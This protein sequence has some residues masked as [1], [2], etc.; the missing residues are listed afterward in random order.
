MDSSLILVFTAF[1]ACAGWLVAVVAVVVAR[2]P[3]RPPVG[4]KTLDLGPEP[5]AVVNFLVH[6]FTVT[7]DAVPA[8]LIDLAARNVVDIEERGPDVFYVRLRATA[9]EPLTPYERRV[10]EHLRRHVRDGVVPAAALTTGPEAES[11]RW[12]RGFDAEVVADAKARGLSQDAVDGGVFTVLSMASAIPALVIGLVTDLRWGGVAF[13]GAISLLG[14]LRKRHPQRETDAGM[15]AGSRWLGVRAELADNPEFAWHSPLTVELWTRLLAYGAAL[16]IASGASRPLPMGVESD[17]HAWSGYGDRWRP[18][19]V[20]YPRVWP[21]AWGKDPARVLVFGAAVVVGL[22]LFLYFYGPSPLDAG[23]FGAAPFAVACLGIVLGVA[24]VA[25]AAMDW[26]NDIEVTGPILR[27]RA[28]GDEDE[29]LRYYV[30]VDDGSSARIRALRIDREQY[31]RLDQ[32]DEITVRLTRNL[33]CVRW[34]I[35][36]AESAVRAG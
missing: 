4:P 24:G 27:L 1:A 18:V 22:G 15:A 25:M 2:T 33:G 32:G 13:V 3:P 28:L 10:V 35:P 16:G 36:A 14:W 23:V 9:D 12:R 7:A 31:E 30:A 6:D 19:R 20:S 5:P 34:I 29:E 11:K 21:P 26:S 17:T 8:T